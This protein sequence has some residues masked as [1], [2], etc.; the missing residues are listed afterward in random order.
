M[1]MNETSRYLTLA[2][3]MYRKREWEKH[4]RLVPDN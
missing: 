4:K 1:S 3:E 2:E